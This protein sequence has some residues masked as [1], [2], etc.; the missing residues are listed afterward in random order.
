[1]VA[2]VAIVLGT[3]VILLVAI[4]WLLK[5][6]ADTEKDVEDHLHDPSTPTVAFVV[7]DGV[8]PAVVSNA[9]GGAGFSSALDLARGEER[10]LIECHA[11]ERERVRG[12]IA[13]IERSAYATSGLTIG[14]VI[15]RDEN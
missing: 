12:V 3:T 13:G 8:D 5:A 2:V 15:F 6:V 7:P 10:L 11:G 1:M 4:P 9:L 14:A